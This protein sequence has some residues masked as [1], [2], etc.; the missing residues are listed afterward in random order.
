MTEQTE[1]VDDSIFKERTEYDSL[2]E[3]GRD[4]DLICSGKST[5]SRIASTEADNLTKVPSNVMLALLLLEEEGIVDR[6][7]VFASRSE[8]GSDDVDS[9][10]FTVI[11]NQSERIWNDAGGV[12]GYRNVANLS[13]LSMNY[14]TTEGEENDKSTFE[15]G[16]EIY[17]FLEQFNDE[18]ELEW[19]WTPE[20]RINISSR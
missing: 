7:S 6:V 9:Y 1:T 19:D 11:P 13:C 16:T 2:K 14:Q 8:S 17:R 12:E 4:N 18:I 15:L 10:M 20:D 3:F 5:V